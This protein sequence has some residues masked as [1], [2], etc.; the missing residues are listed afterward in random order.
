MTRAL[1]ILLISGAFLCARGQQQAAVLPEETN[2]NARYTVEGIDISG[3]SESRM[4][5]SLREDLH[6]LVGAKLN[7]ETLDDLARRVRDELHVRSVHLSVVKGFEPDHVRILLYVAH[8]KAQFDAYVPKFV[9]Q[10]SQGFSGRV[11]G[12]LTAEHS[13]VSVGLVSDGD[14]LAERYT[15]ITA[16]F[17][18]GNLGT[19]RLRLRF[20]FASFQ[21]DWNASTVNAMNAPNSQA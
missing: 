10:S 5:K 8:R 2:V 16:R 17:E 4:S 6:R 9:Y 19:D 3:T 11:E 1:A 12:S 14:E 7:P 21:E 20:Q 15:G 13:T 18:N